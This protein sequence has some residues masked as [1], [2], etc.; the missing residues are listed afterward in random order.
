MLNARNGAARKAP[1]TRLHRYYAAERASK[2]TE[3][4][5]VLTFTLHH[6]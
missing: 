5:R 1:R 3:N 4:R 6:G 2:T